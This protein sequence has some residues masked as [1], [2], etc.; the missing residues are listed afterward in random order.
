MSKSLSLT[1]LKLELAEL[2]S[3]A[4]LTLAAALSRLGSEEEKRRSRTP[5][6][7]NRRMKAFEVVVAWLGKG[8]SS[9]IFRRRRLWSD[10]RVIRELASG[11]ACSRHGRDMS[12]IWRGLIQAW[13][14][15]ERD[16]AR[17][18]PDMG[19]I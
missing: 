12:E 2:S 15:Y 14:R 10:Q 7:E 3:S 5:P 17:P 11:E 8:S 9:T 18:D 19:E 6:Q 16:M 1:Q 13:A 4:S